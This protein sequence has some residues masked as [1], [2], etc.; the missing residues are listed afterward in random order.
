MEY[1]ELHVDSEPESNAKHSLKKANLYYII[2]FIVAGIF[3]FIFYNTGHT[4]IA[5]VISTIYKTGMDIGASFVARITCALFIW[6]IAHSLFTLCNKNLNDS[7]QFMFHTSFLWIH[8]IILIGII[9]GFWFIP[10]PFFNFY[11]KAAVYVSGVYLVIQLIFLIEFFY[12]INQKLVDND[13]IK[14]MLFLTILLT[15]ISIA[16]FGLEYYF[17]GRGS[18]GNNLIIS[19]NL[20]LSFLLFLLSL[21][22]DHGSIFVSSLVCVY[23]AFLTYSGLMAGTNNG[24][25]SHG[26]AFSVIGSILSLIW[27]GYSAFS[28]NNQFAQVCDCGCCSEDENGEEQIFSLSFFH[29]IFGLASIY[30]A[31]L[32]T[33]WGQT[34]E[35]AAWTTDKGLVAKW[36]NLASSWVAQLLYAWTL[37]APKLFPDR[38]FS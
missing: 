18:S 20:I 23:T 10:D 7:P 35:T 9:V 8:S 37:I 32:V 4:W 33:H 3:C 21:V 25:T 31:M 28:V 2:K 12:Q 36:I 22:M 15:A 16:G 5:K 1:K 29:L 30:M 6:F 34:G 27:L 26:I 13:Q 38:D 17:F 19:I 11:M 14:L 24:S